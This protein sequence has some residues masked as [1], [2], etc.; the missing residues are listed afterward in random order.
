VVLAAIAE[1]ADLYLQSPGAVNG[2]L[3]PELLRVTAL[4]DDG[5][6][7]E[8]YVEAYRESTNANQRISILRSIY[9]KDP[10]IVTRALD[11][12]MSDEVLA[13]HAAY[14]LAFY[15]T[16]LEDH[17]ILYD[18]LEENVVTYESNIPSVEHGRLPTTMTGVCNEKNLALMREFFADRGEKYAIVFQRQAEAINSCIEARERN[19]AALMEFLGRYDDN[20]GSR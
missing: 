14:A 5:K 17:T 12:S 19:G 9:F 13:G 10:A 7:Y 16:I 6:R 1:Q 11:F 2:N 18:W 20:T 3:A 15:P 8:K 4:H